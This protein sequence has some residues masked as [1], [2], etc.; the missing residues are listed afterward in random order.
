MPV[1]TDC[2]SSEAKIL[3]DYDAVIVPASIETHFYISVRAYRPRVTKPNPTRLSTSGWILGTWRLYLS[4]KDINERKSDRKLLTCPAAVWQSTFY[5]QKKPDLEYLLTGQ[6][7]KFEVS[8]G[9]LKIWTF[10]YQHH[11]WIS[12]VQKLDLLQPVQGATRTLPDLTTA[13]V[14]CRCAWFQSV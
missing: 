3:Q 2:L 5:G 1:A 11:G 4:S 7:Q 12:W 13:P 8:G 6:N 10:R 14:E 9:L